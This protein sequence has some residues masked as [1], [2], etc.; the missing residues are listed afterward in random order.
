MKVVMFVVFFF[1][2][3]GVNIANNDLFRIFMAFSYLDHGT[4]WNAVGLTVSSFPKF[5]KACYIADLLSTS[6]RPVQCSF[7]F[8]AHSKASEGDVTIISITLLQVT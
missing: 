7:F 2:S 1:F 4:L 3:P 5:F 6:Y 8:P